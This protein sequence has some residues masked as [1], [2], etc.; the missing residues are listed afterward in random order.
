MDF[1]FDQLILMMTLMTKMMM[2]MLAMTSVM[3]MMILSS[4]CNA[5]DDHK[6][7][8]PRIFTWS[9]QEPRSMSSGCSSIAHQKAKLVHHHSYCKSLPFFLFSNIRKGRLLCRL[10]GWSVDVTI[11]FF[12]IYRHKSPL[13][14]QYH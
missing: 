14:T 2:L 13:L 9:K 4:Q 6:G 11:N 10:V 7:N 8:W 12:N 3:M 5:K 1:H